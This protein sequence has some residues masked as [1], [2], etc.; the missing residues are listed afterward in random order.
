M[1]RA[2]IKQPNCLPPNFQTSLPRPSSSGPTL[3][4]PPRGLLLKTSKEAPVQINHSTGGSSRSANVVLQTNQS[5]QQVKSQSP[6]DDSARAY[7]KAV[8][9]KNAIRISESPIPRNPQVSTCIEDREIFLKSF[10]DTSQ[11]AKGLVRLEQPWEQTPAPASMNPI[12]NLASASQVNKTLHTMHYSV[13]QCT[14]TKGQVS[15][16]KFW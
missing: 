16:P 8:T 14:S 9:L 1:G 12:S 3:A 11:T 10:N 5:T 2:E 7:P 6:V 15:Q 13:F 4:C